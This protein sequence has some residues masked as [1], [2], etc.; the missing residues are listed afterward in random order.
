[1][2]LQRDEIVAA[3]DVGSNALRMQI[4]EIKGNGKTHVLEDVRK[5]VT[6]GKDTFTYGKVRISTIYDVCEIL[7]GYLKLIKEYRIKTY[8]A[9]PTSGVREAA[10]RDYVLDQI[11]QKTGLT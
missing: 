7:A 6:I 9:V 2:A 11:H 5:A 3:I 1:M 4:A 8:R 10:N